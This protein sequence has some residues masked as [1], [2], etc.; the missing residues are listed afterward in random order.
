MIKISQ[1]RQARELVE[2]LD[3]VTADLE[4]LKTP[5]AGS[6]IVVK[7]GTAGR[8]LGYKPPL[9]LYKE[10]LTMRKTAVEALLA[11]LGIN[12]TE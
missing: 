5:V 10:F 11:K 4:Q 7:L 9:T 12:V 8:T 1:L 6:Q 3:Q 2:T